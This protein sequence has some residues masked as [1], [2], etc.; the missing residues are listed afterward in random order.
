MKE[1]NKLTKKIFKNL[2]GKL[3]LNK[4]YFFEIKKNKSKK[5]LNQEDI[6]V[7]IGIMINPILLKK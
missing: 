6:V 2:S 4:K 3:L 5:V 7:A 1:E